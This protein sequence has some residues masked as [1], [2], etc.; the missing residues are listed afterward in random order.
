[1][2]RA[3]LTT[4]RAKG[5][6]KVSFKS[7]RQGWLISSSHDLTTLRHRAGR[8]VSRVTPVHAESG[9][10]LVQ[11]TS[12]YFLR[13]LAAEL[14]LTESSKLYFFTPRRR[15]RLRRLGLMLA[16]R[17]QASSVQTRLS[18]LGAKHFYHL[19]LRLDG[20]EAC[21]TPHALW[22]HAGRD[23][24]KLWAQAP[25]FAV[26]LRPLQRRIVDRLCELNNQI[27]G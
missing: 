27:E 10:F 25:L 5:L 4:L 26:A 3:L 23:F 22:K 18:H 15:E 24:D 7:G 17:E 19:A 12:A 2:R 16:L 9:R 21:P 13:S 14:T 11:P 6:P 8:W 1:M 20:V